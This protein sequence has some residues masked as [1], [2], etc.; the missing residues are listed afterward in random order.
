MP[1]SAVAEVIRG[2]TFDKGE[3]LDSAWSDAVPVLRA[4]NIADRLLTEHD[5]VWVPSARVSPEQ[6]M[7]SGD[8]AICMSSG[9]PAVVGKSAQIGRAS[10]RERVLASV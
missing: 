9:S 5:L 3:A 1:L 7:R 2:V 6:R 10:W 8:I 4:G